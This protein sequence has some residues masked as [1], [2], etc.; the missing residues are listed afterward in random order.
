MTRILIIDD[1]SA[2]CAAVTIVLEANGFVVT[3]VA[4]G[5]SGIRAIEKEPFDLAICDLFLPKMNGLEAIK[6]IRQIKPALPVIAA[7]GFMFGGN[8]P[9]MP[10]FDAMAAEAGASAS[11]YKPFKPK[12]LLQAIQKTLAAAAA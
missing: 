2:V 4:D 6:V 12:D 5:P 10:N 3:A 1:D 8:C 7:S 11:L 9:E